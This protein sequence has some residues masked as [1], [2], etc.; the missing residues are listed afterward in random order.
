MSAAFLRCLKGGFRAFVLNEK[1]RI[2][3]VKQ[4]PMSSYVGIQDASISH[5][6]A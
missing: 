3:E 6:R 5:A 2:G 4:D 1:V